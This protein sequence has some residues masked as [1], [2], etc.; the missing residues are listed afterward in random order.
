M[1]KMTPSLVA[2][3]TWWR[4]FWVMKI[5]CKSSRS[6]SRFLMDCWNGSLMRASTTL[7]LAVFMVICSWPCSFTAFTFVCGGCGAVSASRLCTTELVCKSEVGSSR[8]SCCD[9]ANTKKFNAMQTHDLQAMDSM[10]T[11]KNE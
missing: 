11:A 3:K 8:Q 1:S 7:L 5:P 10:A 9:W 6:E 2:V 4:A